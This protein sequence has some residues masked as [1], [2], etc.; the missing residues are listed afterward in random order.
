MA[1]N[2]NLKIEMGTRYHLKKEK[3]SR[4]SMKKIHV[5]L[6]LMFIGGQIYGQDRQQV[7]FGIGMG[8]DYGGV[9]GGK[10]EYLPVKQVGLFGGLGYNLLSAGWNV[11]ATVKLLP[12]SRV[13]PNLIAF[14]GYNGVS[15]IEGASEY[16]MTSYGVTV[17]GNLDI[18]LGRRGNKLSIG[19]FVPIRS[20]KFMDNYDLIKNSPN[21]ELENDLLPIA[22]SVGFNWAF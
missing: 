16:N 22:I 14:Y 7:Y 3:I 6:V 1:Q 15:K 9:F 17:G 11:G 12:D 18:M 20:K 4:G 19:L 8:L 5:F 2:S 10:I 13:S 21:I